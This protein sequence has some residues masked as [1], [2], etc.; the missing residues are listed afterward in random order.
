M[1]YEQRDDT[2]S[3]FKNQDKAQPNHADYQGSIKIDGKSY[4]L[5]AW[6]KT[7]KSGEKYMSLA[8][9]A[10]G[11]PKNQQGAR[12]QEIDS[13]IPFAPIGKGISGHAV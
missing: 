10:K 7:S 12:R 1:A 6:L 11:A 4:W 3:L 5:S 9:K 2:G 13:D 8:V